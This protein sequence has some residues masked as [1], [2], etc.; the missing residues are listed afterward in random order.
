M[1]NH[2]YIHLN[3]NDINSFDL[4]DINNDMY[5]ISN[6][7]ID[8]TFELIDHYIDILKNL[9]TDIIFDKYSLM[10]IL[11][12]INNILQSILSLLHNEYK[13][14]EF[15]NKLY[16][17]GILYVKPQIERMKILSEIINDFIVLL[18]NTKVEYIL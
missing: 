14:K 6:S 12:I 1:S 4:F 5:L 7:C 8:N 10:E 17:T 2:K 9:K 3:N 15:K 13:F 11:S 16:L 18:E